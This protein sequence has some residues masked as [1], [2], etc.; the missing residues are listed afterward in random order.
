MP[1]TM[2]FAAG[3]AY[4]VVQNQHEHW[5]G[6]DAGVN[7]GTN[8]SGDGGLT[9]FPVDRGTGALGEPALAAGLPHCMAVAVVERPAARI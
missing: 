1:W 7:D 4:L 8:G 5:D 9:I 2:S 6:P 3:G